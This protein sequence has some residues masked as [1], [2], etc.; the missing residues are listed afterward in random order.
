M[1]EGNSSLPAYI[2]PRGRNDNETA[3][4]LGKL[5]ES[6]AFASAQLR[7]VSESSAC[8]E[9]VAIPPAQHKLLARRCSSDPPLTSGLTITKPRC[10]A[11]ELAS[12]FDL[13]N[14]EFWKIMVRQALIVSLY[15]EAISTVQFRSNRGGVIHG[16]LDTLSHKTTVDTHLRLWKRASCDIALCLDTTRTQCSG[17]TINY[18]MVHKLVRNESTA[19]K[20]DPL[21]DASCSLNG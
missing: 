5:S 16:R 7:F 15:R 2:Y 4:T 14:S 1:V 17:W 12:S 21:L 6:N 3:Q 10:S 19:A 20:M 9:P 13:M 11:F 8:P 18:C